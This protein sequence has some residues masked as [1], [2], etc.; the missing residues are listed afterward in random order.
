MSQTVSISKIGSTALTIQSAA[1]NTSVT[2]PLATPRVALA[3][4]GGAPGPAGTSVQPGEG[5]SM[6]GG[7]LDLNIEELPLA[8]AG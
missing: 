1:G 4:V 3:V 5:I 6:V 7:R 2:V 8:P